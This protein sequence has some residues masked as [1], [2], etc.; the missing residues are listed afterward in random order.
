[1]K[2]EGYDKSETDLW[3]F[4][5]RVKRRTERLTKRTNRIFKIMDYRFYNE[6]F[7]NNK[8]PTLKSELPLEWQY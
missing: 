8:S 5:W 4:Y 3:K 6:K 7:F 1:M 2:I